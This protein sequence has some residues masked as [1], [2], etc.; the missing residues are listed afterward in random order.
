VLKQVR[1]KS[2]KFNRVKY[3]GDGNI[4]TPARKKEL[5]GLPKE[6]VK[7]PNWIKLVSQ[8]NG[9]CC[10]CNSG[11]AVG[12]EILWN[13]NNKKARHVGCSKQPTRCKAL[14]RKKKPCPIDV[15]SW[16]ESGLCHVHDPEGN[17]RKKKAKKGHKNHT[18]ISE[19]EHTWYMR[20]EG[21]T[22]TKCLIVDNS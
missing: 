2:N 17:F 1:T 14:T 5:K 12:V 19:C 16:R 9:T 18:I 4:L 15:E 6:S 20:Q 13:K 22:C 11:I 21:I 7:G 3:D 10:V 8:Y